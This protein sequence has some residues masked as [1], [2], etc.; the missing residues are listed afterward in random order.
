MV[1]KVRAVYTAGVC[2]EQNMTG[3]EN[4]SADTR[5]RNGSSVADREAYSAIL[6]DD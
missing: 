3:G 2:I 5:F 6:I 4:V 1:P